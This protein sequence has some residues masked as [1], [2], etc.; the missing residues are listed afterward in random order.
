MIAN[1]SLLTI[2]KSEDEPWSFNELTQNP[3]LVEAMKSEI[4]TLLKNKT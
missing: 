2:I 3:H 1:I 4:D